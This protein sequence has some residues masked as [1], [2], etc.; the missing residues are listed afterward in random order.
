M[1][2]QLFVTISLIIA[3]SQVEAIAMGRNVTIQEVPWLVMIKSG[4]N[5]YSGVLIEE[6]VVLTLASICNK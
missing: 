1:K 3:L 2:F 5:I 4:F 6:N